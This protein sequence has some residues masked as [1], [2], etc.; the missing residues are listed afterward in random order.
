[1]NQK[2]YE[3]IQKKYHL[4]TDRDI[5]NEYQKILKKLDMTPESV[6]VKKIT[7]YL[8]ASD[9]KTSKKKK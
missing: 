2:I 1:M 9:E 3:K 6:S 5:L 4:L 7:E 8:D